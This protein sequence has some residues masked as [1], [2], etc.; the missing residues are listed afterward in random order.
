MLKNLI[1][2]L[3]LASSV[4][5]YEYTS[6]KGAC[7][8]IKNRMDGKGFDHK[9]L[10]G[11]WKTVYDNDNVAKRGDCTSLKIDTSNPKDGLFQYLSGF[12]KKD[13]TFEYDSDTFFNFN[14]NDLAT[15]SVMSEAEVI[16][17]NKLLEK[18]LS[19]KS[20]ETKQELEEVLDREE[21]SWNPYDY[22][23][24]ILD[25]DY[26]NYLIVYSCNEHEDFLNKDG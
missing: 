14:N 6:G 25:T 2:S 18:Q 7:P 4:Y 11:L 26:D 12:M 5:G 9:K 8:T 23:W 1:I 15:A 20:G 3:L 10:H 19:K 13:N 24:H 16:D 17:Q 22:Q 21:A